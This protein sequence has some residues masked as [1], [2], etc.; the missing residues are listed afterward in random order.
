MM[1]STRCQAMRRRS[2]CWASTAWCAAASGIAPVA[3]S[4]MPGVTPVVE[5]VG[6][7]AATAMTGAVV[8]GDGVVMGTVVGGAVV[9]V[10]R[11]VVG[12]GGGALRGERVVDREDEAA[13]RAGEHPAHDVVRVKVAHDPAAAVRIDEERLPARP[14]RVVAPDADEI[15]RAHV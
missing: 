15:G 6:P 1:V 4:P 5:L 12:G 8:D 2:R 9:G 3:S 10:V 13:A 14:G 11:G 7:S